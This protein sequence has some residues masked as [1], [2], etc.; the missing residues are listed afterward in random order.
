MNDRL[1][2]P[3]KPGPV[4]KNSEMVFVITS[5]SKR[6]PP[7]PGEE[8]APDITDFEPD[9][10][11]S[12]RADFIRIVEVLGEKP[13]DLKEPERKLRK[14]VSEALKEITGYLLAKDRVLMLS[15]SGMVADRTDFPR[16]SVGRLTPDAR[17]KFVRDVRGRM[18]ASFADT[19]VSHYDAILM[20]RIGPKAH[21]EL[22]KI[23]NSGFAKMRISDR[24]P[25]VAALGETLLRP[26]RE[27]FRLQVGLLAAGEGHMAQ[28]IIPFTELFC[29]GNFPLGTV[30][31]GSFL[32]LVE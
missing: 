3:E 22:G 20:E 1:Y 27:C 31:D 12:Y 19:V 6:P 4:R 14:R 13:L 5:L 15:A 29:A 30:D 17:R 10:L 7:P 18:A 26:Y 28:L 8:T 9:R 32:V 23:V 25:H 11:E 24:M 16:D 21:S 2:A